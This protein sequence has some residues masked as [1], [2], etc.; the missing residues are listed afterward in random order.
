MSSRILAAR[1]DFRERLAKSQTEQYV[2]LFDPDHYVVNASV[3]EN[4]I[5]GVADTEALGG[6]LEDHPYLVS[7]VTETGLE[8]RLLAMGLQVAETLIDLF[9][10]LAPNNP[11]LERMELMAPDEID[12]YRAIV[13]RAGGAAGARS[14]R[15]TARRCCASP[16]AMSSHGSATG[17]STMTLQARDRAGAQDLPREP[18]RTTSRG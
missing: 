18:A 13:R 11:L 16:T 8:A 4:L 12:T 14:I 6:R 3:K 5:F 17:S 2:E 15:R 9:G 7:V 10:D 1:D